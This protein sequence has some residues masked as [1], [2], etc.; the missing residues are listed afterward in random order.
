MYRRPYVIPQRRQ[1]HPVPCELHTG[2]YGH[3]FP[4]TPCCC[5]SRMMDL[6]QYCH[7]VPAFTPYS[8]GNRGRVF[9]TSKQTSGPGSH[10]P[11]NIS[12]NFVQYYRSDNKNISKEVNVNA[13]C[14]THRNKSDS[15]KARDQRRMTEY[16]E[17]KTLLFQMPFSSIDNQD[18]S[19]IMPKNNH[20]HQIIDNLYTELDEECGDWVSSD[21]LIS[22]I[23]EKE[24][25]VRKSDVVEKCTTVLEEAKDSAAVIKRRFGHNKELYYHIKQIENRLQELIDKQLYTYSKF[26]HV[27]PFPS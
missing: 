14:T 1:E 22:S 3:G 18:L 25:V 21:E 6:H 12:G 11:R 7:N 23:L 9:R 17:R 5:V 8:A 15:R 10:K 19:N 27:P 24:E 20:F 4:W 26:K 16:N 2:I 13:M